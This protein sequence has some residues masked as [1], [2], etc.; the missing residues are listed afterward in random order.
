MAMSDDGNKLFTAGGFDDPT[1]NEF[2]LRFNRKVKQ[3]AYHDDRIL[4]LSLLTIDSDTSVITSSS[5][6]GTVK[7]T[8]VKKSGVIKSSEITTLTDHKGWITDTFITAEPSGFYAGGQ[9]K[10]AKATLYTVGTERC[11]RSYGL[12]E[13]LDVV[14]KKVAEAKDGDEIDVGDDD[15]NNEGEEKD[16]DYK[17]DRIGNYHDEQAAFW[18]GFNADMSESKLTK[19]T[20][21]KDNGKR[22][23][24]NKLVKK[25][26]THDEYGNEVGSLEY[27][28]A[29]HE[30]N[31]VRPRRQTER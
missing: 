31:E 23:Q 13:V 8:H 28:N 14:V 1:I 16:G 9:K 15:A 20:K 24:F 21:R 4:S 26:E 17:K 3:V 5:K 19:P 30:K 22:T 6:D 25:K 2:D 29:I 18:D 27:W 7:I 11:L 12:G 10:K